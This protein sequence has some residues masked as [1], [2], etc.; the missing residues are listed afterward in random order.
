MAAMPMAL[1]GYQTIR[2]VS[3]SLS[4]SLSLSFSISLVKVK[5]LEGWFRVDLPRVTAVELL[6]EVR[7]EASKLPQDQVDGFPI[8]LV[9]AH[10]VFLGLGRTLNRCFHRCHDL[11][12]KEG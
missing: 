7:D 6:A 3:L 4:L 2:S 10:E 9:E 5:G 8:L 12:E 1:L 11:A